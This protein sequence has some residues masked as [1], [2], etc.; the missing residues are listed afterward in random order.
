MQYF[1]LVALLAAPTLRGCAQILVPSPSGF[2]LI[3]RLTFSDTVGWSRDPTNPSLG[4]DVFLHL[5]PRH[6][7]GAFFASSP[8]K[9][10]F[11]GAVTECV[12][13]VSSG[14]QRRTNVWRSGDPQA[15]HGVDVVCHGRS[16]VVLRR[17]VSGSRSRRW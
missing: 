10:G 5:K 7:S 12:L 4:G 6:T 13:H 16:P 9:S 14:W 1:F 2:P 8:S 17:T 3:A 15:V 11:V